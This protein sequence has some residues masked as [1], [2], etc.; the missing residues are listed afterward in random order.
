MDEATVR[1]THVGVM[2]Q[3]CAFK[4]SLAE[5]RMRAGGLTPAATASVQG[6]SLMIG[7]VAGL[8]CGIVGL[9]VVLVVGR[10]PEMKRGALFGFVIQVALGLAF[11]VM[12]HGR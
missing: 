11:R 5:T 1:R 2:C 12:T 9:V 8:L 10:G 6:D 7:L 4:Q 3:E